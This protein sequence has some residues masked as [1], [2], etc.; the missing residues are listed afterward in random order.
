MSALQTLFNACLDEIEQGDL[1]KGFTQLSEALTEHR[2][3]LNDDDWTAQVLKVFRSHPL[4]RSLQ[5][6]PYTR[7]ALEKPQGYAGDAVMMDYMNFQ[8]PPSGCSELGERIFRAVVAS[9]N[10]AS[11]RWRCEHLAGLITREAQRRSSLSVLSVACGHCR[12]GLMLQ[13]ATIA[14]IKRFIAL[15]Q[16]AE[17]LDVVRDTLKAFVTPVRMNVKDIAADPSLGDFNLI[18]SAGLFDYLPD[19]AAKA[20]CATLLQR[21]TSGG[22]LLIANFTPDNWGRGY[23]EAVMDWHLILRTKDAMRKLLPAS[24][25]AKSYLYFDPYRNVIYLEITKA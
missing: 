11:V 25:V 17:S 6:D 4:A 21:T 10:G 5:E 12:E 14:R 1:V 18:Y 3:T 23:M 20:L 15:D 19:H 24:Q 16:D 8:Q 7:R 13:P 9:P 22:T 2:L